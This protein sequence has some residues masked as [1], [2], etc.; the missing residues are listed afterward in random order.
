MVRKI[1]HKKTR[2]KRALKII[3]KA[4]LAGKIALTLAEDMQSFFK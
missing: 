4:D 3:E 2:I 1:K